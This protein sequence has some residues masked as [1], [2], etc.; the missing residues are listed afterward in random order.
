MFCH[1]AESI[2]DLLHEAL[3]R[4]IESGERIS[5]SRGGA[6]ELLGVRLELTDPRARLSRSH[7]RGRVFSCLGELVWYLSG[8]GSA[9]DI[10]PYIERYRKEAEDDGIV[11]GAYGTRLFAGEGRLQKAIETLLEK[12]DS[13]QA[14]VPLLDAADLA[15]DYR[16][17]PCTANL[18]FMLRNKRVDMVVFMRSNDAYFGL[19]HDIF[20]FTMIQELVA[21]TVEADL[22]TYV[23]M[24]GSLHLYDEHRPEANE[25]LEEGY[26]GFYPMPPMPTGSPWEA[27]DR[28][29]AAEQALRAGKSIEPDSVGAPYWADLVRLLGMF[30]LLRGSGED[31]PRIAELRNSMHTRVFDVL[32]NDKFGLSG[33]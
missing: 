2:D 3:E 14:V 5:P 18:Q 28:L 27:V 17:V 24:V 20:A 33:D 19:P 12:E 31:D 7:T 16:H 8:S 22:G 4:L 6:V 25:Y 13:R 9:E 23:H 32:L 11:N 1:T 30:V 29:I 15:N 21:R 26:A 10:A